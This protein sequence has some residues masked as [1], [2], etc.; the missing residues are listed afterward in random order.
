MRYTKYK[1]LIKVSCFGQLIYGKQKQI[2]CIKLMVIFTNC[3]R[4]RYSLNGVLNDTLLS[5]NAHLVLESSYL[6]AISGNY[7][8]IRIVTSTQDINVDT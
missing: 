7:V 8:N 6:L 4:C 2:Q 1:K 3:K 5:K